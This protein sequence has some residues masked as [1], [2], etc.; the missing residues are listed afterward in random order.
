[1]AMPMALGGGGGAPL[2]RRIGTV[3]LTAYGVGI[4]VGAG[5]YVLTGAAAGAAG[6]W[7]PLA[8]VLAGLVA[9]PSAL[10]F[11]ELS[12]RIPEAAGDSSYVEVGLG[13]HWLALVVGAINVVA[14]TVAAAAVLRGGVGYL[15]SIADIPFDWAVIGLGLALTGVALVGVLESLAFAA[16]LT[17]VEVSGLALVIF[18]GFTAAPVADWSMPLPEIEGPGLAAATIFAFFAFIGFDDMVNMAEETH[19]PQRNMP[20]AILLA[21]AITAL[22]Y[23]LVSLAAVRAVPREVLA[24]SERPLALV[25]E[26]GMGSSAVFLSAIA[27]AAALNGVLAQIV[28]ASRVLFGLSRRSPMLAVFGHAS[29]RFGTPMVGTLVVGAAVIASAFTLP[30]ATLAEVT[31]LA[32]L[33]VFAVVNAALIG[34][35]RKAPDFP[36]RTPGWMPWLGV[37]ACLATFVASFAGGLA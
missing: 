23:T 14:G 26:S 10:S 7:A 24:G 18:A 3:L 5:I 28:M 30:V 11:A 32:L 12:A 16:V 17:L 2:K 29:K 31:T 8:F 15:V 27:V 36:F 1:M 19:N 37:I 34:V 6:M 35:K 33:I 25:W 13:L 4:M 21:L 20:R 9:I 22:L